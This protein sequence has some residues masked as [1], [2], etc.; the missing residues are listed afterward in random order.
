MKLKDPKFGLHSTTVFMSGGDSADSSSS[1][2]VSALNKAQHKRISELE[3]QVG[4]LVPNYLLTGSSG[5]HVALD[6]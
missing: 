4:N 1:L 5:L 3:S 2:C 6:R